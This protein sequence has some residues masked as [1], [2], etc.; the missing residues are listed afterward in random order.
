[1]APCGTNAECVPL[2]QSQCND[3]YEAG[4]NY[5]KDTYD[6]MKQNVTD[7]ADLEDNFKYLMTDIASNPAYP[8]A[9]LCA[10]FDK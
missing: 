7:A 9:E 10:Y 3:L 1:M 6:T 2:D 8:N 5:A 4:K